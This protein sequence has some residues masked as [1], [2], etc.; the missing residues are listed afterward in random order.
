MSGLLCLG[1][2]RLGAWRRLLLDDPYSAPLTQ[3]WLRRS[4]V[5]ADYGLELWALLDSA[6]GT[7]C[8]LG[9]PIRYTQ[10][11]MLPPR[12]RVPPKCILTVSQNLKGACVKNISYIVA[13]LSPEPQARQA[14]DNSMPIYMCRAPRSAGYCLFLRVCRTLFSPRVRWQLVHQD[15]SRHGSHQFSRLRLRY[16]NPRSSMR[17]KNHWFQR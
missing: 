10:F 9:L 5:E 1:S 4:L 6:C 12:P 3:T 17:R 16:A 11:A 15:L 14:V 13:Y 8:S 2:V 7:G